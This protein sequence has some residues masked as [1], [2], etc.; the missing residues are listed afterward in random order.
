MAFWL[1][2]LGLTHRKFTV[3]MEAETSPRAG[4]AQW[5][6]GT[7]RLL[8]VARPSPLRVCPECHS[9]PFC[10]QRLL[11][12]ECGH[13]PLAPRPPPTA[14]RSEA[15]EAVLCPYG[16]ATHTLVSPKSILPGQ[17]HS[18]P[19]QTANFHAECADA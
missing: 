7:A 16:E 11:R 19:R 4:P 5:L 2:T 12:V 17:A 8:Q 6:R 3:Q 18:G 13:V 1:V 10:S 9:P 15:D 14:G